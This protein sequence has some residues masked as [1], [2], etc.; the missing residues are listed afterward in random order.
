LNDKNNNKIKDINDAENQEEIN[1]M[2][3]AEEL[4]E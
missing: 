4:N 2:S 3:K 1:A